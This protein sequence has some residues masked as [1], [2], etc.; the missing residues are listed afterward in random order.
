M[1]PVVSDRKARLRLRV[2]YWAR[3]LKV[4]P[5][6]VRIQRMS[7]KWGS[8]STNGTISLADDLVDRPVGF[9]DFV[10]VHE[11]LHLR[12][13]NHGRLFKATMTAY[14]PNW[15]TQNINRSG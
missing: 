6:V 9:Q 8:C 13:P 7:R 15:K 3:R 5:R 11:L 10:V 14:A 12:I 1:T 2:E 4:R